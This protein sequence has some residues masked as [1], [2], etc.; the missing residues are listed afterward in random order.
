MML[1]LEF[2]A[3]VLVLCAEAPLPTESG[4]CR[5]TRFVCLTGVSLSGG[6]KIKFRDPLRVEL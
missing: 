2:Y 4:A 6:V 1:C 5:G 3:K